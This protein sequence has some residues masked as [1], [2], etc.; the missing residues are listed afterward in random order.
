MKKLKIFLITTLLFIPGM[1]EFYPDQHFE[2]RDMTLMFA[3]AAVVSNIQLNNEKNSLELV[4]NETLGF[5][6]FAP[7][8]SVYPFNEGLPSWNGYA[9]RNDAAS[10][11]VQMRFA[12]PSGWSP[13]VTVGYWK[14][15]IWNVYGTTS[16]S[17]GYVDIDIIKLNDYLKQWQFKIIIQRNHRDLPSPTINKLSFFVSDTRTTKAFNVLA[18]V[19]EKPEQIFI[20][21]EF[22]HQYS[23]DPVIGGSICSPTS[24]AMILRSYGIELD[25]VQFARDNEDPYWEIFGVWPRVVQNAAEFGLD[26][27]VTRYR[28]WSDAYEVLAKG[29]RIA[30]SVGQPLYAGHLMMLAGFD[31]NGAPIIHDP[32]RSNGYAYKF[33]KSDLSRSWF[34][35][36]G[37]S[38]TFYLKDS[39][40]T[41]DIDLTE[42]IEI[43]DKHK[44]VWNYPNPFNNL[45]NINFIVE[46]RSLVK[47]TI[48]DIKGKIIN[49]EDFG[50]LHV[51]KY[52]TTWNVLGGISSGVYMVKIATDFS[53]STARILYLK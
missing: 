6:E 8:S 36:G 10:F 50:Q 5:V 48:Y 31:E 18:A 23:L 49:S 17:D 35:K 32:A 39:T 37:V 43:P 19:A 14:N 22:Y 44:L 7:D 16:W 26:G 29:G 40:N 13:W 45:T 47:M 30:I 3:E 46:K 38:Y 51:G 15:Y 11:A 53:E 33:N 25:P 34:E 1:A 9:P 2:Y 4:E 28:T 12:G 20:E 41:T 42:N 27:A 24:V 21:T 52:S